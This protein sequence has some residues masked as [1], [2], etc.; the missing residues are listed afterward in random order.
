VIGPG[1]AHAI[2]KFIADRGID[3]ARSFAY[4]DHHSDIHM[5]EMVAHPVVVGNE[6]EMVEQ[7]KRSGWPILNT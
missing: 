5:L 4:G 2:E 7:A 1:K 3:L 6:P